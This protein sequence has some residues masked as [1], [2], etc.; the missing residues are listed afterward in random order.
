[1]QKPIFFPPFSESPGSPPRAV[2]RAISLIR[3]AEVK[4]VPRA[5]IKDFLKRKALTDAQIEQ[6]YEKFFDIGK[7]KKILF[8]SD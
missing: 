8:F 6:A 7:D 3:K 5:K 1:M 2:E 4:S